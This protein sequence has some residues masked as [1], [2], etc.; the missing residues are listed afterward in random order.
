MKRASSP[1]SCLVGF[2]VFL[3][4]CGAEVSGEPSLFGADGEYHERIK[5]EGS[6]DECMGAA[7]SSEDAMA[8][9][10]HLATCLEAEPSET[11]ES[12]GPGET[13]G[14]SESGDSGGAADE[15]G[16]SG[17]GEGEDCRAR[18]SE[19]LD[20]NSRE[21]STCCE[22]FKACVAENW[23]SMCQAMH[24]NCVVKGL[25]DEHCA[26]IAERC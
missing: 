19:C 13:E 23:A 14:P 8:C 12:E 21:Q 16:D 11:G 18:L 26:A 17:R 9:G 1:S 3:V 2:Y 25:S 24:E 4:G 20:A 7:V 15:G 6:F 22:D 10:D 5:C